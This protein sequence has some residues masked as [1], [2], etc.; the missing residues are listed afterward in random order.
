MLIRIVYLL[1]RRILGLAVLALC[2]D[3]AKDAELRAR[4]RTGGRKPK[5][6]DRQAATVRRM[7]HPISGVSADPAGET[8]VPGQRPGPIGT[9]RTS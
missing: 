6:N 5:V 1:V 9:R 7:Y 3:M 4:G 8:A 2:E